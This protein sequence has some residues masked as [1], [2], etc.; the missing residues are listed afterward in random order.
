MAQTQTSLPVEPLTT[1][2]SPLSA[3]TIADPGPLGLAAFAMTTFMLSVF[4]TN[5]LPA[6]LIT[7]VL[8][9]A[10]FY[11]GGVQ[12]LA[13]M[14]EFRKATPS[15]RSRSAP[16]VRSG[17]RT[18]TTS[19]ACCRRCPLPTPTRPRDCSSQLGDLHVL[20][21]D[22]QSAYDRCGRGRVRHADGDVRAATIGA[23]ATGAMAVHITKAG[24]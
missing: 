8:A 24:G 1:T 20:H 2:P 21:G 15:A 3:V 5:M 9:L 10:L 11:G 18:G 7:R 6:T 12:L 22:R 23:F 19:T 16:S 4:N 14:W 17:S 13:G